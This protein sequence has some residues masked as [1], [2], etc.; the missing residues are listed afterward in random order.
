MP[1]TAIKEF[2]VLTV[3]PLG[4]RVVVA[5]RW[6]GNQWEIGVHK[7]DANGQRVA[8]CRVEID[9]S[10]TRRM[11]TFEVKLLSGTKFFL[12]HKRTGVLRLMMLHEGERVYIESGTISVF[13]PSKASLSCRRSNGKGTGETFLADL[14]TNAAEVAHIQGSLMSSSHLRR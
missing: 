14:A 2:F 3:S 6:T 13:S 10:S 8:A 4:V 9:A 11:C 1:G 12:H 5:G 7:D